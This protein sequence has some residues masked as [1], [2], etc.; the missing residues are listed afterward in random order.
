MSDADAP[1]SS[2]GPTVLA[3]GTAA[4][5]VAAVLAIGSVMPDREARD[6]LALSLVVGLWCAGLVAGALGSWQTS[7]NSPRLSQGVAVML[8]A[9]AARTAVE[10][11]PATGGNRVLVAMLTAMVTTLSLVALFRA[12]GRANPDYA[13]KHV[14]WRK[15]GL[16]HHPFDAT[17]DEEHW[18]VRVNTRPGA[19]RYTLL[20]DDRTVLELESWPMAWDPDGDGSAQ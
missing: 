3:R 13:N 18:Q 10:F 17:V 5:G 20:V 12:I 1:R 9:S 16:P 7:G 15:T 6:P 2:A 8:A 11:L 14:S 19:P 4:L